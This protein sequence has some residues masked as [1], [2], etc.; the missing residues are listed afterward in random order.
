MVT[1]ARALKIIEQH[2]WTPTQ[3]TATYQGEWVESGTSFYEM[4]G[5]REQY[6]INEI[7]QCLGY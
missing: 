3:Q 7:Y 2:G 5:N 6:S 4:V 1:K